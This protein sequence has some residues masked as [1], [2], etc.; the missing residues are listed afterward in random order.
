MYQGKRVDKRQVSRNNMQCSVFSLSLRFGIYHP[1]ISLLRVITVTMLSVHCYSWGCSQR[2]AIIYYTVS[3]RRNQLKNR[4]ISEQQYKDI[5]W[6]WSQIECSLFYFSTHSVL[7]FDVFW[8]SL[9][10]NIFG[11]S[12][13]APN[14]TRF[15]QPNEAIFL[16]LMVMFKEIS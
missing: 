5:S 10:T 12:S 4:L 15:R 2:G 7:P 14:N 3:T 9:G 1:L 11:K 8:F 6:D 13:S 16:F